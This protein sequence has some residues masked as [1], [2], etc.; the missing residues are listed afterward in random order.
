MCS[1]SAAAIDAATVVAEKEMLTV[2]QLL[3]IERE[4]GVDDYEVKMLV[5]DRFIRIDET[6]EDSGFIVYDD[7]DKTI[8]SVSHVD[9]SVLVIKQHDFSNKIAPVQSFTEYLLLADAP[10]V[11][12]NNIFNY[13]VFVDNKVKETGESRKET[14]MEIQLAEGFLPNVTKLL[15]NYQKVVAG[16]QVKM[17]DNKV[18]DFQT[19]CFYV[20]QVY[21]EGDY[22]KKGLP[23]QEWHSNDRFKALTSYKQ[24]NVSSDIF[25]VPENY[26]EFSVDK[27]SKRFLQ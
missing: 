7:T 14:C 11:A 2:T 25:S 26:R 9:K 16:Q 8:Y 23:I 6:E 13:R 17:V 24:I 22:Y 1:I 21:N 18:N 3:Y 15:Q 12:G 5:S 20:D 19:P 27:D 10:K 4:P